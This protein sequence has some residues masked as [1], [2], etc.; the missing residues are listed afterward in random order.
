MPGSEQRSAGVVNCRASASK[1]TGFAVDNP[2]TPG[3]D[4]SVCVVVVLAASA[5]RALVF[6]SRA[7]V[8]YFYPPI[9]LVG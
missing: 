2:L 5:N 7:T 1:S 6:G 9:R 4:S 8:H 3:R